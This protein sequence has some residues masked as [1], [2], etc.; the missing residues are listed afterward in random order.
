MANII[1]GS[2]SAVKVLREVIRRGIAPTKL[3]ASQSPR[4]N[5]QMMSTHFAKRETDKYTGQF[6]IRHL[7]DRTF[8]VRYGEYNY[9]GSTDL[10]GVGDIP[11]ETLILPNELPFAYVVL[12]ACYNEGEYFVVIQLNTSDDNTPQGYFDY[13]VLGQV[14]ADGTVE[15]VYKDSSG[16]DLYFGH[17]WFL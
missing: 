6:A 9:A 16:N 17:R 4:K 5:Q 14:H 8:E 10:P 13:V 3:V 11:V 7:G 2:D 15:Q 1:T 12:F